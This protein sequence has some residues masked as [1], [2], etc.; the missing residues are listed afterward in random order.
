MKI[1]AAYRDGCGGCHMPYPPQLLPAKS[2]ERILNGLAD[3]FGTP[4][5]LLAP[6]SNDIKLFLISGAATGK[7]EREDTLRI[8]E[9]AWFRHEHREKLGKETA[10]SMTDCL[11]CHPGAIQGE[12][13]DD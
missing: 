13:D 8:T 10:G 4:V 1:P 12:F 5:D 9:T 11:T 3:H 6:Q 2:W 7:M